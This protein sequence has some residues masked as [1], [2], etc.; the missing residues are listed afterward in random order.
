MERGFKRIAP[1]ILLCALFAACAPAA[2]P[3]HLRYTPGPAVVITGNTFTGDGYTLQFPDG[4]RIVT[5][6]ADLPPTITFVSPDNCSI[7][8]AAVG[9]IEPI[10]SPDCAGEEFQ[11]IQREAAIGTRRLTL[12]GSAPVSQWD[13]FSVQVEQVVASVRAS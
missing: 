6:Q 10:T 8:L 11:T 12:A 9:S 1:V 7:I 4:W 13:Q 5:G 3:E 2:A